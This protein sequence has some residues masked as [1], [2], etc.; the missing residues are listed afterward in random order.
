MKRLVGLAVVVALLMVSCASS[1]SLEGVSGDSL[2]VGDA[3]LTLWGQADDE[4][5][6]DARLLQ[7]AY[8]SG[9]TRDFPPIDPE[10]PCPE[11]D[12]D[13]ESWVVV[14]RIRR[15]C[16]WSQRASVDWHLENYDLDVDRYFESDP[17]IVAVHDGGAPATMAIEPASFSVLV[18]EEDYNC[19]REVSTYFADGNID[20]WVM[21]ESLYRTPDVVRVPYFGKFPWHADVAECPRWVLDAPGLDSWGGPTQQE[22]D[23]ARAFQAQFVGRSPD[24]W[25]TLPPATA[26]CPTSTEDYDYP[27]L[28]VFRIRRGCL[29]A[30]GGSP[31]REYHQLGYLWEIYDYGAD[32]WA[33]WACSTRWAEAESV[34][35]SSDLLHNVRLAELA[36]AHSAAQ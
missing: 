27:E 32:P 22:A 12:D 15:G 13:G 19:H 35:C 17:F 16:L 31:E 23:A 36:E 8:R 5:I 3:S 24:H 20:T 6:R 34:G 26:P 7:Q 11:F 10:A 25:P 2:R 29:F 21:L 28:M 14:Y 4:E 18:D 30:D 1:D 9:G 33:I